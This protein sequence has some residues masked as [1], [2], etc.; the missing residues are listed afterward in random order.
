M[1]ALEETYD[2]KDHDDA[3]GDGT[4]DCNGPHYLDLMLRITDRKCGDSKQRDKDAPEQSL[5]GW[6]FER[7]TTCHRDGIGDS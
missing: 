3:E 1:Q 5:P 6:R 4:A 7:S 2:M